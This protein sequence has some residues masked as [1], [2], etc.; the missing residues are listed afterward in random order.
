MELQP[1]TSKVSQV[2]HIAYRRVEMILSS[3][4]V[5]SKTRTQPMNATRIM[6]G[7]RSVWQEAE[8]QDM[9]LGAVQK[10]TVGVGARGPRLNFV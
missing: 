4:D 7:L 6:Y 10:G 9:S 1:Y 8:C 5:Q 2:S 3:L